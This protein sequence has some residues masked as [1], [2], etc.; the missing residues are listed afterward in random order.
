LANLGHFMS[1]KV[2]LDH[3]RSI[4]LNFFAVFGHFSTILTI[5][6]HF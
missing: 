2:I 4:V 6:A 5:L 3:L 1:F